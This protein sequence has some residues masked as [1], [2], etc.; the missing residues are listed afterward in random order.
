MRHRIR[1]AAGICLLALA[2]HGCLKRTQ[3]VP[4][5][6]TRTANP[7]SDTD[8]ARTVL[9]ISSGPPVDHDAA[10]AGLYQREP[11][12]LEL[13][14]RLEANPAD[15]EAMQT[16][17]E[18]YLRDQLY[19]QAQ[20]LFQRRQLIEPDNA[21]PYLGL[22]SVWDAMGDWDVALE[23][24]KRAVALE[25]KSPQSLE[26]LGRIQLHRKEYD[27]ALSS[28]R[29][30]LEIAPG[31]GALH[32][33]TGYVHMLRSEWEAARP[34]LQRAVEIDGSVPET[35]N[36]LGVVL[37][38]LGDAEG[39]LGQ[40]RAVSDE[41]SAHNNLGAVYL[42][43]RD[44]AKAQEEFRKALACNPQHA[45]AR[46]NLQEA[47][48]H[49]PTRPAPSPPAHV[50]TSSGYSIQVF[51]LRDESTAR[52]AA[53]ALEKAGVVTT[54]ERTDL[55]EG[56]WY[57]GRVYGYETLSSALK[58]AKKLSMAGLIKKYWIVPP[59]EKSTVGS[60]RPSESSEPSR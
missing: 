34:Y 54:V 16:L 18:A 48:S 25:P 33:N 28:F 29:A 44:W 41:A 14:G 6:S 10:L 49:L 2:G 35:R 50:A 57:R 13:A 42:S 43:M 1:V 51:A 60:S 20:R 19:L 3:P 56:T 27:A 58:T 21:A 39:A 12:L 46:S 9:K 32:A 4:N 30:A 26:L 15:T 38:R 37:G 17:A 55:D 22:A 36:N 31:S 11:R 7:P 5:S 24:A 23:Q 45:K 47:G 8:S 52:S 53:K 40:F 59:D